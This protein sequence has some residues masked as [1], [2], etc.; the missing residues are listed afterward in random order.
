MCLFQRTADRETSRKN[1]RAACNIGF[2]REQVNGFDWA[3]VQ[4]ST[5]VLLL[6]FSAKIPASAYLQTVIINRTDGSV[7][8]DT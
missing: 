6:N 4:G 5:F 2:S 8:L 1:R 3:F 7:V